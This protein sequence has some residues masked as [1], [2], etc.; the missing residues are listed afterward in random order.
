MK[1]LIIITL[2]FFLCGIIAEAG[3]NY[4]N[5]KRKHKASIEMQAKCNPQQNWIKI[6]ANQWEAPK[7]PIWYPAYKA[8]RRLK[9]R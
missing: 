3:P 7:V 6:Y 5:R 8:I 9:K 2:F 1:R 4:A